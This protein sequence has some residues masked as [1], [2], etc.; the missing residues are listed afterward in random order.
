MK[1]TRKS[2]A[3]VL[4]D[5]IARIADRGKNISAF[6]KTQGRMVQPSQRVNMGFTAATLEKLENAEG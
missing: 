1:K 6:F 4:A 5:A 2:P 3:L